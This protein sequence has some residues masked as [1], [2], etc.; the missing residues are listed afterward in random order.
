MDDKSIIYDSIQVYLLKNFTIWCVPMK[1]LS[2]RPNL[3][4]TVNFCVSS[5]NQIMESITFFDKPI[6]VFPKALQI[7]DYQETIDEWRQ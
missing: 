1:H 3:S 2:S 7:V 4:M 5:G 6:K